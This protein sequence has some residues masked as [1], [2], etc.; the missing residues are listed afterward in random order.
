M[1][2]ACDIE[3]GRPVYRF[4]GRW[5]FKDHGVVEEIALQLK[6]TAGDC[7]FD[8]TDVAYIDSAGLGMMLLAREAAGRDDTHIVLRGMSDDLRNTMALAKFDRAFTFV[9]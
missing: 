9:G 8:L 7:V 2:Y 3:G 4:S 5:T 6:Q 1:D